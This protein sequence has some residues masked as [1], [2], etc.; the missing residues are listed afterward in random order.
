[1]I[2]FL[3]ILG[4]DTWHYRSIAYAI[5]SDFGLISHE[6]CVAKNAIKFEKDRAQFVNQWEMG[7]FMTP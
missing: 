2:I 6:L 1:M 3:K 5:R 7:G 4:Q